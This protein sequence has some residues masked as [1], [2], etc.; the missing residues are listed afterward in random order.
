[1]LAETPSSRNW[2]V[3]HD[4]SHLH[5][6]STRSYFFYFYVHH[7]LSLPALPLGPRP[8]KQPE[9]VVYG[10]KGDG[11][12]A[13]EKEVWDGDSVSVG[14]LQVQVLA[15]P[16][17]TVGHVC[18]YVS[19]SE[20]ASGAVFTGDTLFVAGCGNFNTG[21]PQQMYEALYE[22]LGDLPGDTRVYVGHE[23]TVKNLEYAATVEPENADIQQRLQWAKDQRAVSPA[24]NLRP[25]GKGADDGGSIFGFFFF[26]AGQQTHHSIHDC[27]RMANQPFYAL[28]RSHSAEIY[29]KIRLVG[30]KWAMLRGDLTFSFFL[31]RCH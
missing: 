2:C 15:T 3:C 19:G 4:T 16:C 23:Y 22:K 21:S 18:Y 12:Q 27:R 9:V 30:G 1:M 7:F 14:D 13:V 8:Q 20:G 25:R 10:G 31:L 29:W 6:Y 17:H 5:L 11:A 24:G 26:F 28:P